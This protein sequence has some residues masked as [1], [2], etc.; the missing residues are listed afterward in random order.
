MLLAGPLVFGEE[1][2]QPWLGQ[3][4]VEAAADLERI[5]GRDMSNRLGK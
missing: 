4:D 3:H 2:G 5:D 1:R